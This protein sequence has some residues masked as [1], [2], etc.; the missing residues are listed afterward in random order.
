MT[1][2][3]GTSATV[4]LDGLTCGS[5][6][7]RAESAIANVAGIAKASVSLASKRA[8]LELAH[9]A[10]RA[11]VLAAVGRAAAEAGYPVASRTIEIGIDGMTCASCAGRVE[12]AIGAVPGVRR[13][14]VNL[15][16]KRA[17]I[18]AAGFVEP[19]TIADAVEQAGY[20]PHALDADG[21]AQPQDEVGPLKRDLVVAAILT[22][23]VVILGMGGDLVPALAAVAETPLA[24]IAA[25]V[26]TT[27]VLV[28]P[29]L[30]FYRH[31]L[32]ALARLAPDMNS[33]VVLGATAAWGYSTVATFAPRWL[34]EG[35][36]DVYFEAAAVIVTLI[37]LGRLL[38]ARARGR[39][40][41]AIERLI[42]LRAKTARV[43]R[44]GSF[45]DVPLEDVRVGDLVQVRPG[46]T[47]P[48][49]GHVADGT[50]L[51]DESMLTGE[52]T[53]VRKAPGA[54]VTGATLN[55]TGSF[56][57]RAEKV[58]RE[59]ML[60]AIIRM[61]EE[62]QG[63]KL[64]IQALVDRVTQWFVPAVMAAAAATFLA[65]MV[66][67]PQPALG[68]AIVEA[69]AVL[70]IACPCAMGLATPVSIMVGTGRAAELGVLFRKGDALQRLRDARTVAFDK[71]G[72]LT[73]GHPRL[74]DLEPAAG[75]AR[76]EILRMVT[77]VESASEH[78]IA[79]ALVAAA[80]AAGLSIPAATGFDARPG[81][82]VAA[83]VEG[84]AVLVGA[85]RLM[86]AEGLD[87]S[88]F[89]ESARRLANDARTPLFAAIDGRLAALLAIADPIRPTTAAAIAAL[90]D[91]GLRVAMVTGDS[92]RT[93]EAVAR[94]LCIDTVKAEVLPAGKVAAI[95]ALGEDVAFVGDGIND[96]PA[97]A[98]ADV[99]LAVG[100]GT[101]VAVQSADVV[102]MSG[103]LTG[104]V[105]AIALSRATIRNIRQNLFWAFGYNV[106][107]IPVAAGALFPVFG[108]TLSPMLAAGA[109]ALSSVFVVTNALRLKR[110][111]PPRS[112]RR[113]Q[114]SREPSRTVVA[115]AA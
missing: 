47:V 39:A 42:G 108:L 53:P 83:E 73:E 107:L 55:T 35:T 100:T 24:R 81:L 89:A 86:E 16:T 36:A 104:V 29:G 71:T 28:G 69:V 17:T 79:A 48:V 23:P 67:G 85:A 32:P 52:P 57:F 25:F 14:A 51:V 20:Q 41:A 13:A 31:G 56:T 3:P 95:E 4:V 26:L 91:L 44:D 10:D 1:K 70:I 93:A 40:G 110:F 18:E 5:C 113:P 74:T 103:D 94:T 64:P 62:A 76:D 90:H 11:A 37:L 102:L 115:P 65:W 99:G 66:F 63:A 77:A 34:P 46:E 72:T 111:Q 8:D 30:R 114:G 78:P 15:A 21:E 101:D 22:L 58:G 6:V 7:R 61:V 43:E 105:T 27:L 12:R 97:L 38:E 80:K 49:D 33:L 82:G 87:V 19:Q 45:V 88:G 84:H 68:H 75:F 109:M 98:A 112:A 50:S 106:V 60:A 96:A 54:T 2:A 59:T 9:G 92:T